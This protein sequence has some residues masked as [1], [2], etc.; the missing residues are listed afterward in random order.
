MI[1]LGGQHLNS[2]QDYLTIILIITDY[3]ICGYVD[4]SPICHNGCCIILRTVSLKVVYS[5]FVCMMGRGGGG[6]CC[7]CLLVIFFSCSVLVFM[8]LSIVLIDWYSLTSVTN[9]QLF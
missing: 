4:L 8:I 9:I 6:L 7:E 3:R 1:L 2:V 5:N